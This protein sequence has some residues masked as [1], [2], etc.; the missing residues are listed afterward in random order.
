MACTGPTRMAIRLS[1]RKGDPSYTRLLFSPLAGGGA[2]PIAIWRLCCRAAAA[3]VVIAVA[4]ASIPA[5]ASSAAR[6]QQAF[7]Q[8][9]K[10]EQMR[11]ALNGRPIEQRTRGEYQRLAD[12]YRRVYYLAPASSKADDS[13]VAVAEVLA[14]MGRQFEPRAKYLHAAIGQYAFLRREYPGSGLRF[15][16][17]FTMG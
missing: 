8:F 16:A 5:W 7:K 6:H 14:E 11:E 1:A 4:G 2:G 12:A 10:A 15:Q 9:E 13:V 17:L 3:L